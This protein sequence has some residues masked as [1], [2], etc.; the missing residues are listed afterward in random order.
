[1]A[2]DLQPFLQRALEQGQT[3][4]QVA[5]A[6][7]QAGWLDEEITA[8]L[9]KFVLVEGFALPVP[10]REPYLSAR[11][12]FL[13]LVLFLTLYITAV[14]FGTLLFTFVERAIPDVLQGP[15]SGSGTL[16]TIRASTASLIITFPIFVVLSR[17]LNKGLEQDPQKRGSKVRKWLTYLTLFIA[18]VSIIVDLII[19][20]GSLLSGELGT[21]FLFKV[22]IV[23]LIAGTAFG[24]YLWD[25]RRDE[26]PTTV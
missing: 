25:L 10:R 26:T 4:D 5:H 20:V 11:E 21:R 22:A 17:I 12:A 2:Y 13:Y 16:S 3:K 15:Y 8:S 14:S 18:A 6:L 7:K 23:L 9:Q 19:L 1:M 24:Y